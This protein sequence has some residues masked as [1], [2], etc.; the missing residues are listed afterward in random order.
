MDT[1]TEK[2]KE[3]ETNIITIVAVVERSLDVK[4]V[5]SSKSS[6]NS[7]AMNKENE[8]IVKIFKYYI[9]YDFFECGYIFYWNRIYLKLF[10]WKFSFVPYGQF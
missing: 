3:S 7:I 5:W 2:R 8:Q 1:N 4:L 6:E 9:L 10:F